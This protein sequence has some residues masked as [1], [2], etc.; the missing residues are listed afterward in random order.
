MNTYTLH[1]ELDKVEPPVSR[2]LRVPG[3]ISMSGLHEVL[4][5]AFGWAKAH[6]YKFKI[7]DT[8][9]GLPDPEFDMT[10]VL[11]EEVSVDETL[12]G[13]GNTFEYEYDFGDSWTH[14]ITV[15]SIKEGEDQLIPECLEGKTLPRLKTSVDPGATRNSLRR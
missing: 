4:Q 14:L 3:N 9:I 6:L 7:D 2:R 1:V 8:L 12:P 11:A 5:V 15:K 10:D 13:E